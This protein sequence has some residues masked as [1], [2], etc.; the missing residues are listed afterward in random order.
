MGI[1]RNRGSSLFRGRWYSSIRKI[2]KPAGRIHTRIRLSFVLLGLS[3]EWNLEIPT[4]ELRIKFLL[5]KECCGSWLTLRLVC[6]ACTIRE[7][8]DLIRDPCGTS[9]YIPTLEYADCR[10]ILIPSK[11]RW[12]LHPYHIHELLIQELAC[13]CDKNQACRRGAKVYFF[14]SIS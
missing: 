13:G 6:L 5:A 9:P 14:L 1:G 7:N 10:V 4:S 3:N 8:P 12:N 2:A 11:H